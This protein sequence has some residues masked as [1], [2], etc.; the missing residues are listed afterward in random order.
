[1]WFSL[2]QFATPDYLEISH[3]S[4]ICSLFTGKYNFRVVLGWGICTLFLTP[5]VGFLYERRAPSGAFAPFPKQN[6]KFLTNTRGEGGRGGW[7]RLE[8]T[9]P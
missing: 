9:E 2:H 6:D 5:T 8:L 4:G 1:M 3:K 7:G